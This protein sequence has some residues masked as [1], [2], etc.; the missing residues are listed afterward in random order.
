M[1]FLLFVFSELKDSLLG[2]AIEGDVPNL[3]K[4]VLAHNPNIFKGGRRSVEPL[5]HQSKYIQCYNEV[6][7]MKEHSFHI[8]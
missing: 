6:A 5:D 4:A 2:D 3:L 7:D 1:Q 8:Y